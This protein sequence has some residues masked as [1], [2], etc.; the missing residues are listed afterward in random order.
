VIRARLSCLRLTPTLPGEVNLRE[1]AF[2]LALDRSDV[3]RLIAS[4]ALAAVRVDVGGEGAFRWSID[5]EDVRGLARARAGP[6]AA[7]SL[8]RGSR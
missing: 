7:G 4:G 2:L 3:R 5:V 1:A 8:P 6:K